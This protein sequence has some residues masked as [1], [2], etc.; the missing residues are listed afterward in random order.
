MPSGRLRASKALSTL[1]VFRQPYRQTWVL[2][3]PYGTMSVYVRNTLV[4]AVMAVC[5]PRLSQVSLAHVAAVVPS[6][7]AGQDWSERVFFGT[8]GGGGVAKLQT[9]RTFIK[10]VVLLRAPTRH[11]HPWL[12]SLFHYKNLQNAVKAGVSDML[13]GIHFRRMDTRSCSGD[14]RCISQS[15][16][17]PICQNTVMSARLGVN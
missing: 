10:M 13:S 6:A 14:T 17:R 11:I 7:S 9:L 4:A 1:T 12:L 16:G 2:L 5:A 8:G 3:C 15:L